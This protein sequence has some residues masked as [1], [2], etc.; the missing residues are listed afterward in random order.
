M[1]GCRE[2]TERRRWAR[3]KDGGQPTSLACDRPVTDRVCARVQSVQAP[4][5]DPRFDRFLAQPKPHELP[6]PHHPMLPR[7]QFGDA[8]IVSASPRKPLLGKG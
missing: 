4:C 5:P 3:N 6:P 2:M 8:P 7:R 1:R